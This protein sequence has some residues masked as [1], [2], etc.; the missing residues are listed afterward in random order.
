MFF[1]QQN[2][3]SR[4]GR[5]TSKRKVRDLFEGKGTLEKDIVWKRRFEQFPKEEF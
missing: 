3:S 5:A 1:F 2:S 4:T